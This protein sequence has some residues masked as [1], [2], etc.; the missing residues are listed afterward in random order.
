MLG[1]VGGSNIVPPVDG[2]RIGLQDSGQELE[3]GGLPAPFGPT[4]ATL[5]SR[6]K[7]RSIP[8]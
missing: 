3:E 2:P 1:K 6:S 8:E 5:S 4:R 7:V